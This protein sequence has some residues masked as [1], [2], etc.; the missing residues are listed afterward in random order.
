LEG[1]FLDVVTVD[2]IAYFE[3]F[4][5]QPWFLLESRYRQIFSEKASL[6]K[7]TVLDFL[8]SQ[9]KGVRS[10]LDIPLRASL[11]ELHSILNVDTNLSYDSSSRLIISG[12]KKDEY[13]YVS[14]NIINTMRLISKW[15]INSFSNSQ[16]GFETLKGVTLDEIQDLYVKVR[17]FFIDLEML[18]PNDSRFASNRFMEGNLFTPSAKSDSFLSFNEAVELL[19]MVYSGMQIDQMQ[20]KELKRENAYHKQSF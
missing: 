5:L 1:A 20:K 17:D 14:L 19:V 10:Y 15:A 8:M 7:S 18:R 13:D 3:K 16:G 9:A 6:P 2:G 4:Y 11:L 12:L